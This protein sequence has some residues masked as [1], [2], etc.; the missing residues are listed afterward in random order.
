MKHDRTGFTLIELLVVIAIIGILA[1][2]L[3]PAL[4]RARESAHR[5]SCQNNLKQFGLVFKMYSG[6]CNGRFPQKLYNTAPGGPALTWHGPA[7]Y[8]EYLTDWKV[9][10]CPSD[11]SADASEIERELEQ[12]LTGSLPR[13][14]HYAHGD[15]NHD[16]RYDG[17]DQAIYLSLV[18]SYVYLPWTVTCNAEMA[19]VVEAVE[20]CRQGGGQPSLAMEACDDD[21]HVSGSTLTYNG[22]DVVAR[23]NCGADTLY[24]LREGIERFLITDINNAAAGA[25]AQ[26]SVPVMLDI[27][28]S[29][30]YASKFNHIPG[31]SNVL[32]MDG[33]V[34]YLKYQSR[35][36]MTK[37]LAGYLGSIKSGA[38]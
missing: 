28:S 17:T 10:L 37:W 25:S 24:R 7:L 3:L 19:G 29:G 14:S 30:Q 12:I 31:G 33:H 2:I 6:E 16:G 36:P 26:S 20:A 22:E 1:A 34:E 32:Y 5:A 13:G 9:T 21:L 4:A 18:R 11:S 23:G 35:F 38:Q 15:V 8:P 27:F